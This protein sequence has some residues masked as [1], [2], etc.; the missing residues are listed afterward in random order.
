MRN[1]AGFHMQPQDIRALEQQLIAITADA[2]KLLDGL[3]EQH[4]TRRPG[5]KSW[6]IAE[7]FDHLAKTNNV[8]LRAMKYPAEKARREKRLRKGPATPGIVGTLFAKTLEPPP[9]F[10]FPAP[11]SIK[12]GAGLTLQQSVSAFRE[13]HER[14]RLFLIEH[15]DL[16]LANIEF[17][18]PLPFSSFTLAAAFHV[19]AA[20][21]RRHLWQSWNIRRGLTG[22]GAR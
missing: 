19:L 7:C 20:H 12:P 5:P 17:S 21:E 6:S 22:P 1:A 14:L 11:G 16:D 18:N 8:Y 10:G 2:D 9:G 15:A 3:S 4:G 13:S